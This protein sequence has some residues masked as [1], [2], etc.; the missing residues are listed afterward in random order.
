MQPPQAASSQLV[1]GPRLQ[2]ALSVAHQIRTGR[3]QACAQPH[4]L[5]PTLHTQPESEEEQEKGLD[6][7]A[8]DYV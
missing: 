4:E 2:E 7:L 8:L 6:V 1:S 3:E 5:P